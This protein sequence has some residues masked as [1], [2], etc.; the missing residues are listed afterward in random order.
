MSA[1]TAD[2]ATA[3]RDTAGPDEQFLVTRSSA[4]ETAQLRRAV[5]RPHL[6]IEEMALGGDQ[7]PDTTYLCVRAAGGDGAVLGCLRLEPMPCPWSAELD[8]SG[9]AGWQLRAMA[10]DPA[11][12]GAGLGRRLVQAAVDHVAAHGGDLIWCNARVSAEGFYARQGFRTLTQRFE[13]RDVA[14]AHVGMV[15]ELRGQG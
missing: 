12:R 15:L 14:E 5:L 13:L 8:V 9:E 1:H 3:A 11:A 4:A 6:R 7:N 2:R 10:T